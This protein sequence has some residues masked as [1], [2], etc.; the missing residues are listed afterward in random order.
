[1]DPQIIDGKIFCKWC[2]N[3]CTEGDVHPECQNLVDS[4]TEDS[5]VFTPISNLK[6]I[7]F[8]ITQ[9][10]NDEYQYFMHSPEPQAIYGNPTKKITAKIILDSEAY[11]QFVLGEEKEID[12]SDQLLDGTQLKVRFRI[13]QIRVSHLT[14]EIPVMEVRGDIIE[15]SVSAQ[16]QDGENNFYNT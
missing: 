13:T 10:T 4:F 6:I 3:P 1:M 12:F 2:R 11:E 15:M 8:E 7:E 9:N 16:E 14:N 5:T